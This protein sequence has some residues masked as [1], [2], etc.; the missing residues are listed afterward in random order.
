[1]ASTCHILP[2]FAH[3]VIFL[4]IFTEKINLAKRAKTRQFNAFQEEKYYDKDTF[5]LPR[6][7]INFHVLTIDIPCVCGI[8][9][10][11]LLLI[12]YF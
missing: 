5:H 8:P 2:R 4:T 10:I 3:S 7:Y 1:M 6:Q 9:K 11:N 12:Y